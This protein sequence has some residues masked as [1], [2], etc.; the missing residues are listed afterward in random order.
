MTFAAIFAIV[1][2][3]MMIGQ[4][5][6]TIAGNRVPGL[7]AEPTVGRGAMEMQF[8]WA[9]EFL[10]AIA[11]IAGGAGL[12][13]RWTRGAALFFIAIGM[14]LYAVVNSAGY[15]AQQ[16]EWRMVGVFA[17]ILVLASIGVALVL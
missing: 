15:F 17:V 6:F 11:L 8:H 16:G 2:G 1:V 12:L 9:A 3:L 4:W 7:E 10:T 5:T 13:V 14:L